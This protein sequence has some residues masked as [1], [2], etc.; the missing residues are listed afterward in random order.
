VSVSAASQNGEIKMAILLGSIKSISW[1]TAVPSQ[2]VEA[3]PGH[4]I[5]FGAITG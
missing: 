1:R 4:Q 2:Q 5:H 3:K